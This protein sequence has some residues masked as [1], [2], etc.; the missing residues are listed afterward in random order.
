[1]GIKEPS[2]WECVSW[3][4]RYSWKLSTEQVA[5]AA[6]KHIDELEAELKQLRVCGTC[7]RC[8]AP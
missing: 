6:D 4:A 1:M 7:A 8:R 2:D 5:V 3:M